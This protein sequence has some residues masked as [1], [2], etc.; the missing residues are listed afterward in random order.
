[1]IGFPYDE[2]VKLVEDT[3]L[4]VVG[5]KHMS[6]VSS[7][8]VNEGFRKIFLRLVSE[9][10]IIDK[11]LDANELQFVIE[12]SGNHV[13]INPKNAATQSVLE[14][15]IELQNSDEAHIEKRSW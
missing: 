2:F 10:H 13:N 12:T 9:G 7:L 11:D 8:M 6:Q 1:M 3:L 15:I 5:S 4:G 14:E